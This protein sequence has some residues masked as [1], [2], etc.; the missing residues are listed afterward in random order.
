MA[1]EVLN[2]AGE[3]GAAELGPAS[4]TDATVQVY[5]ETASSPVTSIE[6]VVERQNDD[7]ALHDPYY[8][9]SSAD[10]PP[11]QLVRGA[12]GARAGQGGRQPENRFL[13]A[14]SFSHSTLD[15]PLYSANM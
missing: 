5:S 13:P 12:G 10:D 1:T 7:L 11:D 15:Q 2:N 3:V 9:V 14:T 4:L 6:V 8:L